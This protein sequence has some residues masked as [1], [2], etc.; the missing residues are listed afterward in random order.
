[1]ALTP[2]IIKQ[3]E[4]LKELTDEQVNALVT[5]STNDEG[6][7]IGKRIG[8]I[9]GALDKDIEQSFG[10]AK[11]QGEKT[12]D[13]LKRV[14]TTVGKQIK[15][16]GEAGE[17]LATLE[18][19]K[20]EL[21]DKMK[22]G[23]GTEAISQKLK[24][25][26]DKLEQMKKKYQDDIQ[27]WKNKA[28]EKEDMASK[29]QVDYQFEKALVGKAFKPEIAE[30]L[31]GI[32]INSAKDKIL[33]QYTPDWIDDGKGGQVMV[34]RNKE[35]QIVNNPDRGLNPFTADELL[36]KEL[37][38]TLANMETAGTGTKKPGSKQTETDVNVSE[39]KTQVEA[40]ERIIN[41]LLSKGLTKG[42]DAF[43]TEHKRI[44]EEHKVAELPLK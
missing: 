1:M 7:V 39:A 19:E 10:I 2:E 31:Q 32:I 4:P 42:S 43:D 8:E 16:A 13:Y 25:T 30:D 6:A 9:Y 15:E 41:S 5:L 26:T 3:Q 44:R 21:E 38:P 14:G 29:L 23:K 12:Y 17:K 11:D 36:V 35:G 40:D 37:K 22:S 33:S 20:R 28:K 24:D 34:F 27:E 18:Q